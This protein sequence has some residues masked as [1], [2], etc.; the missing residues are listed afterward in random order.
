MNGSQSDAEGG[1]QMIRD[2]EQVVKDVIGKILNDEELLSRVRQDPETIGQIMLE[3]TADIDE[4]FEE[5][6]EKYIKLHLGNRVVIANRHDISRI[7]DERDFDSFYSY[8]KVVESVIDKAAT[9]AARDADVNAKPKFKLVDRQAAPIWR[10]VHASRYD[11]AVFR[12][13]GR[14]ASD[15]YNYWKG[16][17]CEPDETGS[18]ELMKEHIHDNICSGNEDTYEYLLD[19]MAQIIQ[20]PEYK[21]GIAVAM[22]GRQG[23]G[24]T[25]FAS[26]FSKLF[27]DAYH[28][29]RNTDELTGRFNSSLAN[30][31]LVFGDEAV[32]G[33]NKRSWGVI[34]KFIT[35]KKIVIEFKGKDAIMMDNYARLILATNEHWA[36]PVEVGDRR[37]VVLE[38]A[39]T[40]AN[41]REYFGAIAEQM[42]SGGYGA[43]LLELQSRDISRRNWSKIPDTATRI[44]QK[45]MG[46]SVFQRFVYLSLS[47][48]L[49]EDE[50]LIGVYPSAIYGLVPQADVYERYLAFAQRQDKNG[51]HGDQYRFTIEWHSVLGIPSQRMSRKGKRQRYYDL[52]N[53]ELM[54][55]NFERHVD[56][57]FD[58]GNDDS[59]LDVES[60]GQKR[61]SSVEAQ[62]R[63][64][65]IA[66]LEVEDPDDRLRR[67]EESNKEEFDYGEFDVEKILLEGTFG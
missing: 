55:R 22:H 11:L 28:E 56:A 27:G 9:K 58:W 34:K 1:S 54:R 19:W 30:K 67:L 18:W 36:A 41:N 16:W 49:P 21:P 8:V 33:G 61:S 53:V 65:L 40:R 32:W 52:S 57:I 4:V 64:G 39:D 13:S 25:F 62:S 44:E 31:L 60:Y 48:A 14:C 3:V 51:Y 38:V 46:V 42:E 24:K 66:E 26:H 63:D 12:P 45:L 17:A 5:W 10:D 7:F 20:Q 43:M 35:D 59:V 15:E 2:D 47:E 29:L 23:T 37:Y 50:S 6:N